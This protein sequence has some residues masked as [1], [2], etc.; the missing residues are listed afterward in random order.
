MTPQENAQRIVDN[1]IQ[2]GLGDPRKSDDYAVVVAVAYLDLIETVT[3]VIKPGSLICGHDCPACGNPIL[4]CT[5]QD[6]E[7]VCDVCGNFVG[8]CDCD[9]DEE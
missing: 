1:Y 8:D 5:C 7:E 9:F 3:S 2:H 6:A 4:D